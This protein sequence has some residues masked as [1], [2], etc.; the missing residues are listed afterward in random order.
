[1]SK[2]KATLVQIDEHPLV[3]PFAGLP[4]TTGVDLDHP[5]NTKYSTP[6][7]AS[8]DP[9]GARVAEDEASGR[10]MDRRDQYQAILAH[11][12]LTHPLDLREAVYCAYLVRGEGEAIISVEVVHTD[13][14]CDF[15]ELLGSLHGL[16]VLA[17]VRGISGELPW[18]LA[19]PVKAAAELEKFE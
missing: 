8:P 13:K 9:S 19:L 16:C 10:L 5:L 18:H 3:Q 15:R 4:F 12:I 7:V 2:V 6:D 17:R 1:M 14:G 11:K